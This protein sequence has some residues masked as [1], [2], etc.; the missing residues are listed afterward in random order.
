MSDTEKTRQ[1]ILC[2]NCNK[3]IQF[4]VDLGLDGMHEFECPE[5]GHKHF[6]VVKNGEITNDR[7]ALDPSHYK[8][9]RGYYISIGALYDARV[10][11]T[12]TYS[13]Y[14]TCTGGATA[15]SCTGRDFLRQ[16]WYDTDSTGYFY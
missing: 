15:N 6:R 10:Y 3:Y 13:T 4:E 12:S 11:G 7:Y 2:H 9:R 5:C 16:R 14:Y 1:E 8:Q